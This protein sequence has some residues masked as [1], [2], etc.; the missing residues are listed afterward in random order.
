M[1][2]ELTL[3]LALVH[4]K[5]QTPT[6]SGMELVESVSFHT[7]FSTGERNTDIVMN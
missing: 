6:C 5:H 1:M 2:N 4:G 7:C 3:L